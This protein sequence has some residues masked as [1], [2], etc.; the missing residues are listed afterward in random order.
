MEQT[1]VAD[2]ALKTGH[3][4]GQTMDADLASKTSHCLE[5]SMVVDLASK[6]GQCLEQ[7]G[8]RIDSLVWRDFIRQSPIV[9]KQTAT[10]M[11]LLPFST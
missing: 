2:L 3:C 7:R 5:Q 8:W 1:M 11:D 10:S 6:T 9:D 4:L